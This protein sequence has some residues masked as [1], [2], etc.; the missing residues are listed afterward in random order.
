MLTR[1][2]NACSSSLLS[3]KVLTWISLYLFSGPGPAESVRIYYESATAGN[4]TEIGKLWSYIPL[5]LS[6][7]PRELIVV[8]KTYASL[9]MPVTRTRTHCSLFIIIG[10]RGR[11]ATWCSKRSTRRADISPPTRTPK[12]SSAMSGRCLARAGRRT[13][14]SRGKM[15]INVR[16][17]ASHSSVPYVL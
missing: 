5:G 11:W 10:G 17:Q 2:T 6:Y 4:F 3:Y 9:I 16:I 13:T 14:W 8:P 12:S 1:T 15:G 7:F